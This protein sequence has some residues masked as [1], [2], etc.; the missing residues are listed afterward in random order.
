MLISIEYEDEI[1][2][3][4]HVDEY[5]KFNLAVNRINELLCERNINILEMRIEYDKQNKRNN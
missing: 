4:I 1:F 5:T 3:E 2:N